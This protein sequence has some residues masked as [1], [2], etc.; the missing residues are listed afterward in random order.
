[1]TDLNWDC[2]LKIFGELDFVPLVSVVD[3]DK[4]FSAPVTEILRQK[5]ATKKIIVSTPFSIGEIKDGQILENS[6]SIRIQNSQFFLKVLD[7]FGHLISNLDIAHYSALGSNSIY[8]FINLFCSETLKSISLSM[9]QDSMLDAFTVPFKGVES[10]SIS[11]LSGELTNAKMQLSEMFP[12]MRNLTLMMSSIDDARWFDCE[13]QNLENVRIEL[14]NCGD[15]YEP[16]IEQIIRKNP[17]I[18]GLQ[19]PEASLQFLHFLAS[20]T[21]IERLGIQRLNG[22]PKTPTKTV[23]FNSLKELVL[24]V[25]FDN[26]PDNIVIENLEKIL[27][28]AA[29]DDSKWIEFIEKNRNMR[30]IYVTRRCINDDELSRITMANPNI[31]EIRGAFKQDVK[32]ETIIKF[33]ENCKH[34]KKIHFHR[35]FELDFDKGRLYQATMQILRGKFNN[36]WVFD[37]GSDDII[38]KRTNVLASKLR[39]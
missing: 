14:F 5:F 17:R 29:S 19:L 37:E 13:F 38:L 26:L 36:D 34:L 30:N 18:R 24:S 9:R 20:E 11:S 35:Y 31:S 8:E 16:I 1:M 3:A 10:V 21:Q 28:D 27:T 7:N 33:M 39:K 2:Q 23:R 32:D 22:K 25:G 6:F 4:N 15:S 12:A